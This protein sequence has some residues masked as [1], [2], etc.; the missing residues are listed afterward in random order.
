MKNHLCD[1][2]NN[3]GTITIP[4]PVQEIKSDLSKESTLEAKSSTNDEHNNN[5]E[6]TPI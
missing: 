1:N 4:P 5:L 3:D 6:I 2:T